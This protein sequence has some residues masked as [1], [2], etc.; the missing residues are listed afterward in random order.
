MF[1]RRLARITIMCAVVWLGALGIIR[2]RPYT[3]HAAQGLFDTAD[4]P[5]NPDAAD[6]RYPCF[7]GILVGVT[8]R[9]EAMAVL[10]GHPWVRDVYESGT[11]ISWSWSGQQPD[12]IDAGQDGLISLSMS[13]RTRQMR[14]LTRLEFGDV[15]LSQ[16]APDSALLV[17]PVSR[18]T[19]Y[20]IS[21]F[22]EANVQA[23][24]TLNCP[25]RPAHYWNQP[26]SLGRGELWNTEY[27]NGVEFSIYQQPAWWGQLRRCRPLRGS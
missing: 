8:M 24:T 18:S 23:I 1:F 7:M 17:R 9:D 26:V 22:A 5:P 3:D 21:Y 6:G 2:A 19:A 27:I 14:I 11:V 13:G 25:A 20:Q 15:W 10:Q 12:L 16:G 4:C